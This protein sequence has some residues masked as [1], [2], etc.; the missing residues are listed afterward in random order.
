[1]AKYMVIYGY[2]YTVIYRLIWLYITMKSKKKDICMRAQSHPN[3][4]PENDW[5]S[6]GIMVQWRFHLCRRLSMF[7]L[8]Y[9]LVV[10]AHCSWFVFAPLPVLVAG[11]WACC[12]CAWS[13]LV[14]A[15]LPV[16]VVFASAL[17]EAVCSIGFGIIAMVSFSGD[18][19]AG[20]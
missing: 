16:I 15:Q 1:M 14:S 18:V 13:R 11:D 9:Y 17:V 8:V 3:V 20:V 7:A 10:F 4:R 12:I 5:R 19:C 6:S 2:I